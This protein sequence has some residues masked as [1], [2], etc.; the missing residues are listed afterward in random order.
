MLLLCVVCETS[1]NVLTAQCTNQSSCSIWS[2][3]RTNGKHIR[4]RSSENLSIRHVQ[5]QAQI[6]VQ[7]CGNARP[8]GTKMEDVAVV[9]GSAAGCVVRSTGGAGGGGGAH[10]AGYDSLAGGMLHRAD[11]ALHLLREGAQHSMLIA[12]EQRLD[13][14]QPKSNRPAEGKE[15]TQQ[16]TCVY[17]TGYSNTGHNSHVT[18]VHHHLS[19]VRS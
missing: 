2:T 16:R 4:I 12:V 7:G 17:S 3:E 8:A 15:K 14:A 18:G 13:P 9:T 6:V 1:I 10:N 5:V 19:K 11:T